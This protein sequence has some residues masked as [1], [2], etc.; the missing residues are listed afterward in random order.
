MRSKLISAAAIA[1]IA[2]FAGLPAGA[3]AAHCENAEGTSPG[4]SWFGT[5]HVKNADHNGDEPGSPEGG[6][7]H[8]GTPG[9]SNCRET[10]GSPSDSAPG[11]N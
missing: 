11:Q 3:S 10:A 8:A 4:F 9:A 1:A 5:V 2:G 7:T 6:A